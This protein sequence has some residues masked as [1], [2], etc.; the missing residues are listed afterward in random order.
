MH[1]NLVCSNYSPVMHL[2]FLFRFYLTCIRLTKYYLTLSTDYSDIFGRNQ[3][4]VI[5][6]T[7]S[8]WGPAT[9]GESQGDMLDPVLFI[10]FIKNVP[11][12]LSNG[13]RSAKYTMPSYLVAFHMLTTWKTFRRA[14]LEYIYQF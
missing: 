13:I 1:E 10:L 7:A 11:D 2:F 8:N 9:F 14:N 12:T 4:V 3:R 5:D 6:N